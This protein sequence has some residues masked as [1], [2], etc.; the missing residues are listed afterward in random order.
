MSNNIKKHIRLSGLKQKHICEQIGV[1]Q[2]ALSH[3]IQNRRK[4]S[5]ELIK[6]LSRILKV[7]VQDL[8]P[9]AK[10]KHIWIV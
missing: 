10:Q 6:S 8:F 1:K 9:N 4:P 2:S 5:Q 7:P 3:V